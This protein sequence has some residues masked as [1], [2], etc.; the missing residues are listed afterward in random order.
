MIKYSTHTT[1]LGIVCVKETTDGLNHRRTLAPTDDISTEPQAIQ[2]A[3]DK[4]WTPEVVEA[5]Q[6]HLESAV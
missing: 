2:D 6:D 4:A 1:P 5:Y 3:C